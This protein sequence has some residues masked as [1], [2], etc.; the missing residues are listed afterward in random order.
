MIGLSEE[1]DGRRQ[2]SEALLDA[3]LSWDSSDFKRATL[4]LR[5]EKGVSVQSIANRS[6]FQ[7]R[8]STIYKNFGKGDGK[9]SANQVRFFARACGVSTEEEDR[10]VTEWKRIEAN[11]PPFGPGTPSGGIAGAKHYLRAMTHLTTVAAHQVS[12]TEET[13][14]TLSRI[15]VIVCG[16]EAPVSAAPIPR[17][18]NGA[19]HDLRQLADNIDSTKKAI[20]DLLNMI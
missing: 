19:A 8:R 10:W 13:L 17:N 14:E 18:L 4:L 12:K 5:S 11:I 3:E 9:P 1:D 16:A 7:L 6:N 2:M 20:Q 15:A